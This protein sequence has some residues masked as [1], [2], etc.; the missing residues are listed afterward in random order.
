MTIWICANHVTLEKH[1]ILERD[2]KYLKIS[3]EENNTRKC[4]HKRDK[5]KGTIGSLISSERGGCYIH[6]PAS[7]MVEG[8]TYSLVI[9]YVIYVYSRP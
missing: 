5:P 2:V 8:K 1:S 3:K 9:K 7:S 4:E 6:G